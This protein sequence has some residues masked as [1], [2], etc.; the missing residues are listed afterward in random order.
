MNKR[1]LYTITVIKC[2]QGGEE[3]VKET[4]QKLRDSEVD[5]ANKALTFHKDANRVYVKESKATEYIR[6][7][8]VK[9]LEPV[10]PSQEAEPLF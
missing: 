2:K 10:T 6:G 4:Y 7:D 5:A 9:A 8:A 3:I 1:K